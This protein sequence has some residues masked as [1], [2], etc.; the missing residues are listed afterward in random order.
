MQRIEE[1]LFCACE[2]VAD[3]NWMRFELSTIER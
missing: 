2:I 3:K 1:F